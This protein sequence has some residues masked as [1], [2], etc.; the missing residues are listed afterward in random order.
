[1]SGVPTIFKKTFGFHVKYNMIITKCTFNKITNN[2]SKLL[3]YKYLLNKRL[4]CGNE[5][6][7]LHFYCN[8]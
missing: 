7:D 3:L 8:K 5:N 2:L 1:M 4:N 6:S